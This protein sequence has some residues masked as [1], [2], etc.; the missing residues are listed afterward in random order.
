MIRKLFFLTLLA[1]PVFA[2]EPK[3]IPL[4]PGAAPGSES[5]NYEE[6]VPQ[7]A[8]RP[9]TN[10]THPTLTAYFPDPSRATGTA[11]IICP[12]GG[13]RELWVSH[14]GADLAHW[15]NS[16]GVAAFILKYRVMRTG[17]TDANDP[18]KMAERRKTVIPLAIADGQQ[19]VRLVRARASCAPAP[20]NGALPR[21]ESE[22]LASLLAVT[23]PLPSPCIMI[24]TAAPILPRLSIPALLMTLRRPPMRLRS[25]SCTLMT[26]KLCRRSIIPFAYMLPGRNWES[27]PRCTSIPLAATVSARER[28]V[29]L[30]APGRIAFATGSTFKDS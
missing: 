19:A 27:P 17:D 3:V 24:R 11:V 13:F 5:W 22:Y 2:S 21:I 26:T 7:D 25:F 10:V 20:L 12:G 1:A 18:A 16:I 8:S 14:E 15:L 29:C 6:G 4:W 30:P 23:S 9:I 28:S